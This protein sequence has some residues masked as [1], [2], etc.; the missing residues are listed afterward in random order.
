VGLVA[1]AL[2][3]RKYFF[4]RRVKHWNTLELKISFSQFLSSPALDKLATLP[5]WWYPSLR[6]VRTRRGVET[7]DETEQ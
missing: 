1:D 7:I 2:M 3:G 5:T 4:L 6:F